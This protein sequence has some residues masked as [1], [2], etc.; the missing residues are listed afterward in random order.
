MLFLGKTLEAKKS[1]LR[2]FA[3]HFLFLKNILLRH[4]GFI[5]V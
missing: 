3:R 5:S 1:L 2:Y 4:P